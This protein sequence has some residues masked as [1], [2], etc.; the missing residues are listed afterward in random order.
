MQGNDMSAK[1]SFWIEHVLL[2]TGW[3]SGVRMEVSAEGRITALAAGI[4]P[5]PSDWCLK[6][7]VP[8]LGNVHS[9]AFQRGMAG[10]AEIG[11]GARGAGTDSFWSW[12]EVMYRFLDRLDPESFQAIAEQAYMEMLEAGFTRVGEFHYLHHAPGGRPYADRGEMSARVAAA[13][14]ATGIGLTLLP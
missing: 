8:G 10:L 11:S 14:R 12:R 5:D 9:H 4:A 6:V 13:A 3:T 1:K 7:V 2:P